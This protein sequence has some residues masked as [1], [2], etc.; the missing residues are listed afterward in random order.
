MSKPRDLPEVPPILNAGSYG[1]F[2]T[3]PSKTY[4][5]VGG[6]LHRQRLSFP[7]EMRHVAPIVDGAEEH[8]MLADVQLFG[9]HM[10][11]LMYR[12]LAD[13]ETRQGALAHAF[14]DEDT[15]N[16]LWRVSPALATTTVQTPVPSDPLSNGADT[17]STSKSR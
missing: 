10:P 1:G 5:M 7:C 13:E 17:P 3:V 12:G 4:V 6:P 9:H 2:V 11:V 14:L 16:I 15:Y 8:Y